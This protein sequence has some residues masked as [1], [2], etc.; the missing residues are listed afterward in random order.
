MEAKEKAFVQATTNLKRFQNQIQEV[1]EI[2]WEKVKKWL[3]IL[4]I[5]DEW[6]S[7]WFYKKFICP[8][9]ILI[10]KINMRNF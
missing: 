5:I 8:L 1:L 7:E 9:K 4:K 2:Y 3:E 6:N 10:R